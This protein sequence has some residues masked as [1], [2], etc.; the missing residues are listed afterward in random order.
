VF[1]ALVFLV[2]GGLALAGCASGTKARSGSITITGTTTIADVKTG[3]LIRCK[4]GPGAEVPSPGQGVTGSADGPS[5]SG[6]VQVNHLQDGSVV[7][8]CRG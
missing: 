1:L 7:A 4:G 8:A 2:I 5:S 3:A 6:E